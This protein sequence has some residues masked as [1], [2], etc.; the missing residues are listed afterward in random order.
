MENLASEDGSAG[1]SP[2]F[3][4]AAGEVVADVRRMA[5]LRAN[6]IGDFVL[7]L[8]ALAAL[9]A[10]YPRAEITYL[11]D[12]W[13]PYL[14]DG[15]SGPWDR[16]DVVPPYPG[17]VGNDLATR[18]SRD[19]RQFLAAQRSR[20]YDLAV[21]IHGGGANSNPLV[22][23]LGARITVG[24]RDDGAPALDREVPYWRYQHEVHRFL[25][26]AGLVGAEP[27]GLEPRLQVESVDRHAAE[28]VL[29]GAGD[30]FVAIHPGANDARRRWP[31]ESFAAVAEALVDQGAQVVLVGHGGDDAA[32][33]SRI[34]STA[35]RGRLLNLVGRLSLSETVGVLAGC[36]LL[37]GNDSGP[38]HLAAAVGTPT[39]GIYWWKNLLNTGP[40]TA[41]GSR[42][43]VSFRSTCPMCG[44]EQVHTRCA[45]DPSMVADVPVEEVTDAALDLYLS[46]GGLRPRVV[47]AG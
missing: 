29:R 43:A 42:V 19:V 12:T 40:L 37:V 21:Q 10:A 38:R 8:P 14:L 11:G 6:S 13:H 2:T 9:R 26:V 28:R 27:V 16:V 45:H 22:S 46:A 17:V 7:A 41:A 44:A 35:R 23:G 24:L 1:A 33:A 32:A 47:A 39:V 3:G 4:A 31:V 5:V 20:G 25:E 30:C 18:D 36:R 34:V 15:R